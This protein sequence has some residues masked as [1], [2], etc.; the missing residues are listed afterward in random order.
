VRGVR[1]P[2]AEASSRQVSVGARSPGV[3]FPWWVVIATLALVVV[4]LV[5]RPLGPRRVSRVEE[6]A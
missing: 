4:L 6:P 5:T 2:N 3:G 1:V